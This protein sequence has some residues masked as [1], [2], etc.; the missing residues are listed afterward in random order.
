MAGSIWLKKH[1]PINQAR[2]K[3]TDREKMSIAK[4]QKHGSCV[5]DVSMADDLEVLTN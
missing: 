5:C 4:D 1:T 3:T 2:G